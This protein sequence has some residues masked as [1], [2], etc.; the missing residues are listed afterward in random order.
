MPGP[1]HELLT[2]A[3]CVMTLIDHQP[4]MQFG[5]ANFDRQTVINNTVGLAKAA[6]LFGMPTVLS[7]VETTGFSGSI[8]PQLRVVE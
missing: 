8:W 7:T 6:T 4:Q 1:V 5:V 2:P 3:N